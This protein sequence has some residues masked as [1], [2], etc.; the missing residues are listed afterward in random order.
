MKKVMIILLAVSVLL[1]TGCRKNKKPEQTLPVQTTVVETTEEIVPGME[2]S[3]FDD[4]GKLMPEYTVPPTEATEPKPTETRPPATIPQGPSNSG[5]NSGSNSGSSSGSD[6]DGLQDPE[7]PEDPDVTAPTKAPDPTQPTE[8]QPTQPTQPAPTE[9]QPA[10]T[11]PQEMDY[12]AYHAMSP[13]QQQAYMESFESMEAFFVWYEN[14]KQ[15]YEAA[16]PPIDVG[17]GSIDMNEILNGN[18]G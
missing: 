4:Q 1:C 15:E 3:A 18:N 14:A 13:A 6:G 11:E 17:N 16:N 10:P 5:Y 8:P 9:T 12:A 7:P 2:I